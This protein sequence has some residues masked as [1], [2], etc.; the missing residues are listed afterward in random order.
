MVESQCLKAAMGGGRACSHAGE[1]KREHGEGQAEQM[2]D[3]GMRRLGL[4][5]QDL[6]QGSKSMAE[7]QVLAWWIRERTAVG[8][9]WL[10]QRLWMGEESG[11]TRGVRVIERHSPMIPVCRDRPFHDPF[12]AVTEQA[13]I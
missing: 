8:R 3:Q 5:E 2:L 9:R 10:S 7:K 1:A 13:N 12:T 4:R 6:R 11:V